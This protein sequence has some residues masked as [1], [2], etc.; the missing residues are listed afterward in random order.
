MRDPMKEHLPVAESLLA[1]FAGRPRAAAIYGDLLELAATSGRTSFRRAYFN[2]LVSLT[3]RPLTGFFIGAIVFALFYD[4]LVFPM[5]FVFALG[6]P[7]LGE[8]FGDASLQL[9]FLLPF[10]AVRYGVRDRVVQLTFV[11]LLVAAGVFVLWFLPETWIAPALLAVVCVV[12]SIPWWRSL[13]PLVV[14]CMVGAAIMEGLGNVGYLYWAIPGLRSSFPVL[15][16]FL[17]ML[18]VAFVFSWIHR[19]LKSS[20]IAG[21]THA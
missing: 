8:P 15:P 20:P 1:L 19:R 9:C 13:I 3:W 7:H 18:V 21:A 16:A 17:N 14:S 11:T 12:V 6:N 10:A 4:Y 5:L 2:T